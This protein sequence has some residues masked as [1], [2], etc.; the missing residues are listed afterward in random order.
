MADAHAS[1]PPQKHAHLSKLCGERNCRL[2][3]ATA[4]TSA[5]LGR[6]QKSVQR[7]IYTADIAR[8][9]FAVAKLKLVRPMMNGVGSCIDR[10]EIGMTLI[11]ITFIARKANGL[12]HLYCLPS[13]YSGLAGSYFFR[14]IYSRSQG[15]RDEFGLEDRH[16]TSNNAKTI[17][18]RKNKQISD[19]YID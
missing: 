2:P 13:K 5:Q 19:I 18:R 8:L 17:S 16:A 7:V 4:F 12:N 15:G 6:I 9:A 3:C 1:S 11:L 10:Y 14:P